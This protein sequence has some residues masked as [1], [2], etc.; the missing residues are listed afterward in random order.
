MNRIEVPN[1]AF[2][3]R[4]DVRPFW[5][6]PSVIVSTSIYRCHFDIDY[7]ISKRYVSH[8]EFWHPTPQQQKRYQKVSIRCAITFVC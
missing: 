5:H 2:W 6:R 1:A 8:V 4:N 7:P 3:Y